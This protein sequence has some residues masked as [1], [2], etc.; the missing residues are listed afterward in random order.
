MKNFKLKKDKYKRKK[1]YANSNVLT[2][3]SLKS[4]LIKV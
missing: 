1:R 3:F 2:R 4:D